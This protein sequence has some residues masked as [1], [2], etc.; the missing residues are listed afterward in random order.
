M[1]VKQAFSE[2]PLTV[3]PEQE[4][5]DVYAPFTQKNR[6]LEPTTRKIRYVDAISEG[7]RKSLERHK[8]LAFLG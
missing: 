1:A 8:E 7:L 4:L 6:D 2:V 5:T 3:N